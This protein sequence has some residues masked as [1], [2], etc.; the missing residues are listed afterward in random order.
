MSLTDD[1]DRQR[2][3]CS[4]TTR[5]SK[6]PGGGWSSSRRTR[7]RPAGALVFRL[8]TEEN[9]SRCSI[10]LHGEAKCW[11]W[12][13]SALRPSATPSPDCR[14]GG[15][16]G[17]LRGKPN[18]PAPV[19]AASTLKINEWL[20]KG[21]GPGNEDFVGLF[22]PSALPVTLRDLSLTDR[23]LRHTSH[24]P[25]PPSPS[26]ARGGRRLP[27]RRR[28]TGARLSTSPTRA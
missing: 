28:G 15:G 20:A 25:S 18:R 3:S 5:N 22:N 10:C 26:S 27:S 9:R 13:C 23:P 19:G 24:G 14:A 16:C 11:T 8:Q 6:G 7:R 17:S 4:L 12:L 1:P 2:S 21:S